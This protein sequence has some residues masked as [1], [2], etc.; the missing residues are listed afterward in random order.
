MN[1][2]VRNYNGIAHD[3]WENMKLISPF[4][5]DINVLESRE[6]LADKKVILS[7]EMY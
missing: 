2:E 5:T 3:Y 1:H 7:N 6:G 4:V